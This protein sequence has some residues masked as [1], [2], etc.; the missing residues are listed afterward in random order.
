MASCKSPAMAA[1]LCTNRDATVGVVW[2]AV[3]RRA[4]HAR[5]AAGA[6]DHVLAAPIGSGHHYLVADRD[7]AFAIETSGVL[8]KVMFS[9]R[10]GAGRY[11]HTNHCLDP[12]VAAVSSVSPTSTTH[13]RYAWLTASL[14]ARP[15]ADLED[16][17]TRMGSQ[18][19]FNR[20]VTHGLPGNLMPAM[21][22]LSSSELRELYQYVRGL[23]GK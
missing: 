14:A 9:G 8:R 18:D 23:G 13:E 21:T 15:I 6:R 16:V 12:E 5:T 17:W 20:I 2:P 7:D 19:G 1:S 11:C 4:L 22:T 3:V 10:D